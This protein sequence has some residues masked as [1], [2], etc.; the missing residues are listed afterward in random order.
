MILA[1]MIVAVILLILSAFA[2]PSPVGLGWIGLAFWA[3]AWMI[4]SG[5][6][7]R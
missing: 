5:M 7:P 3:V 2:I 6:L 1:L 4:Q